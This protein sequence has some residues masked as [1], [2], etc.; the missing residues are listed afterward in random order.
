MTVRTS[1]TSTELD[2]HW[3]QLT[4]AATAVV[5]ETAEKSDHMLLNTNCDQNLLSGCSG[6]V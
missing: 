6:S 1:R 5:M 2:L 3:V 4:G